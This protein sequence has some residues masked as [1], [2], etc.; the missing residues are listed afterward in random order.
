MRVW[1]VLLVV[2]LAGCTAPMDGAEGDGDADPFPRGIAW[3]D[4][5]TGRVVGPGGVV[6]DGPVVG[7][8]FDL[9]D[10]L[11]VTTTENGLVVMRPGAAAQ[12]VRVD[13]LEALARPSADPQGTRVVVQA[14][15]PT[16]QGGAMEDLDVFVV[17]LA[18]GAWRRLSD[19]PV[20]EESP[21]WSADGARIAFSSFDPEAGIGLHI[22]DETGASVLDIEDGGGIHLGWSADGSRLVEPGRLRVYD[23]ATGALVADLRDAALD[24]L[25]A[26]GFTPETRYEGQAGRG[27]FPLDGAF[28]PDGTR[29]VFDGAV[30]GGPPRVLVATMGLDGSGF[31]VVAGPFP[32]DPDG[33]NG[34]NFSETNPVWR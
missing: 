13:G 21:E 22:V 3:R 1:P 17:S 9:H 15:D 28:S 25:Q 29:L 2:L 5:A 27:T 8:G 10:D 18:D 31:E 30:A 7:V 33:T 34:L 12:H 6:A 23:A 24:G 26:A 11:L 32:V 16:R 19:R 14:L 20:N 4:P